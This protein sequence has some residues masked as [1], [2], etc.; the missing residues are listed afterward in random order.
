MATFIVSFTELPEGFTQSLVWFFGIVF[1]S[2]IIPSLMIWYSIK[3]RE[4]VK[5]QHYLICP[6]CPG[7]VEITGRG[8]AHVELN[9]DQH[10]E[11]HDKEKKVEAK[12]K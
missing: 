10:L 8:I 12:K 1:L 9:F 3:L 7:N 4:V 11:K 6:Y 2:S 5:I